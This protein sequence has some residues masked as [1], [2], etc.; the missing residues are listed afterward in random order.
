MVPNGASI[1]LYHI[2]KSI[3]LSAFGQNKGN[4]SQDK[5]LFTPEKRIELSLFDDPKVK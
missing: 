4:Y 5:T 1:W 3:R 2:I